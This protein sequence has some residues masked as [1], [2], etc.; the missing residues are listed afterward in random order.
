MN[1]PVRC[2]CSGN[3]TSSLDFRC[4]SISIGL[5]S[6]P[7][8]HMSTMSSAK[9]TLRPIQVNTGSRDTE[10]RL[11]LV[12]ALLVAVLV[13]LDGEEHGSYRGSWFLEAGFGPCHATA[14]DAFGTLRDAGNWIRAQLDADAYSEPNCAPP[15][16]QPS[17]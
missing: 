12:D 16:P 2:D 7:N 4:C 9:L 13:R 3:L 5:A 17:M 14:Q 8:S 6:M 11:V 15:R 1:R 10:G